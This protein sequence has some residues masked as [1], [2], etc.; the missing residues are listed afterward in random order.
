WNDTIVWVAGVEVSEL[1]K[2]T[3]ETADLYEV[4]IEQTHQGVRRSRD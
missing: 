2:V 4:A 1:F 3:G